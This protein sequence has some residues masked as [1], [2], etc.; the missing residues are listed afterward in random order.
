M[1]ALYKFVSS[2]ISIGFVITPF[3]ADIAAV[4]G[5]TRNTFASAVPLLPSKLRL[6]V[7][8]LMPDEFGEKPIP[9]HG[10]QAH[11]KSLAPEANIS[12][13]AP[14][15]E[16]CMSTC[17]DPGETDMLTLL[18]TVLPDNMLAILSISNRLEFVHE[19]TQT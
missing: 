8:R 16:S 11:S 6:N 9:I 3:I 12:V 14:D 10:P 15:S 13:N 17:F 2:A 18:S 7:L 5:D 4:S 19:P 1:Y